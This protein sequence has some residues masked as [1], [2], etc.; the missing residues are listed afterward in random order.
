MTLPVLK[1]DIERYE[2]TCCQL[3]MLIPSSNF[4]EPSLT[5]VT[6]TKGKVKEDCVRKYNL[7]CLINKIDAKKQE[8]SILQSEK[9]ECLVKLRLKYKNE[10]AI[11]PGYLDTGSVANV[12][13]YS[14]LAETFPGQ[15]FKYEPP[16]F[17]LVSVESSQLNCYGVISLECQ[18]S[19]T[20]MDICVHVIN[21]G[22]VFLLGMDSI[23]SFRLTIA[24]Y[25]SQ[26]FI[27]LAQPEIIKHNYN[28]ISFV[29]PAQVHD[30][31]QGIVQS[32]EFCFNNAI[33]MQKYL[34]ICVY[35]LD[36]WC[37]NET[38]R[39]LCEECITDLQIIH[40]A[41]VLGNTFIAKVKP[42]HSRTLK[43]N[44]KFQ[45]F[46]RGQLSQ[47][48]ESKLNLCTSIIPN[49]QYLLEFEKENEEIWASPA[50]YTMTGT[51]FHVENHKF[52]YNPLLEKT[53]I[54]EVPWEVLEQ[55]P[56]CINCE[57]KGR[58][59]CDVDDLECLTSAEFRRILKGPDSVCCELITTAQDQIQSS[60]FLVLKSE[61][62]LDY[63]KKWDFLR[64]IAPKVRSCYSGF[65]R[66][67][68]EELSLKSFNL[69]S[70]QVLFVLMIRQDIY[71]KKLELLRQCSQ[72][73]GH[74]KLPSLWFLNFYD[75]L[76]G[77]K[78][79]T[80][81]FAFIYLKIFIKQ[82]IVNA[83]PA[84]LKVHSDF[85]EITDM[86][87]MNIYIKD[88]EN[89]E[90]LR[91]I[92]QK[93]S[94]EENHL[95]SV[96]ANS[97]LDIG[98]FHS[99]EYPYSAFVF[100]LPFKEGGVR[101]PDTPE[102]TRF[103]SPAIEKPAKEMIL[104][105][106]KA[107]IIKPYFSPLNHQVVWVKKPKELSKE[108]YV[109]QGNN[110]DTYIPGTFDKNNISLR[111]CVDYFF[112][113][114]FLTHTSLI[115]PSP[116]AQI[117]ALYG[118]KYISIFDTSSAFFSMN[119]SSES[120]K[121]TGFDTG[122]R[123]FSRSIHVKCP[124]GLLSSSAMLNN[125]LTYTFRGIENV[126]LYSDNILL[127]SKTENEMISLID[128]V[129]NRLRNHGWR[130][131]PSKMYIGIQKKVNIY[132][133]QLDL[134]NQ[135]LSPKN[136]HIQALRQTKLPETKTALR[137]FL[138][139]IQFI[140][141][142]LCLASDDLANLYS[143]TKSTSFRWN[144]ETLTSFNNILK[145]LQHENLIYVCLP[146][147]TRMLFAGC[148][149]S[150]QRCSWVVWQLCDSN[151][152]R[153][154]SYNAK[155]FVEKSKN[156]TIALLELMG[157]FYCLKNIYEEFGE[158]QPRLQI[159]TDSLPIL[160]CIFGS[161]HNTKLARIRCFL[162]SLSWVDVDF[163]KS[164]SA[165]LKFPDYFTRNTAGSEISYKQKL[166][167]EADIKI[168]KIYNSKIDK[169][170]K[171]SMTSCLLML[172]GLLNLKESQL[173]HIKTESYALDMNNK[174]IYESINFDITTGCPETPNAANFCSCLQV[175]TRSKAR[176]KCQNENSGKELMNFDT[177]LES[178]LLPVQESTKLR[179]H[180]EELS[181]EDKPKIQLFYES[182]KTNSPY[183]DKFKFISQQKKDPIYKSI[184]QE[185]L[186]RDSF[187]E[188]G[189]K[190]FLYEEL[191]MCQE[192]P[193]P[194]LRF[195]KVCIPYLAAHHLI[196]TSHRYLGHIKQAKLKNILSSKFKIA[197]FDE[198][199]RDV[200]LQ[201]HECEFISKKSAATTRRNFNKD[202][203]LL[204]QAGQ[205]WFIDE[206]SVTN[207]SIK[208]KPFKMLVA[209]DAFSQY[210]VAKT[211]TQ[212]LTSEGF[213]SFIQEHL[214]QKFHS[215]RYIVTDNDMKL[216]SNLVNEVCLKLS[217]IKLQS[218]AYSPKSNLAELAAR[219]I[220][221]L[222]RAS[223]PNF[224]I[225]FQEAELVLTHVLLV[226]N[227][228]NFQNS[229][230]LSPYSLMFG[231]QSIFILPDLV[232]SDTSRMTS[233]MEYFEYCKRLS[234]IYNELRYS[235]LHYNEI[236]NSQS[237]TAG[238][239][240]HDSQYKLG[241]II[242]LDN[243]TQLKGGRFKLEPKFRGLFI[244]VGISQ[245]TLYFRPIEE[246][247]I[248]NA[249]NHLNEYQK[250]FEQGQTLPVY[251]ADKSRAKLFRPLLL[252]PF[253]YLSYSK[254]FT[255]PKPLYYRFR[256]NQGF[257]GES[258][259]VFTD[260]SIPSDIEMAD[261]I[262]NVSLSRKLVPR[263]PCI[264]SEREK[265]I[266]ELSQLAKKF[267]NKPHKMKVTFNDNVNT[268]YIQSQSD[269]FYCLPES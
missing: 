151:K 260:E 202:P 113:N 241:D 134:E 161:K 58:F 81:C 67:N 146:D 12:V 35:V 28:E 46:N 163:K 31:E 155:N 139:G 257:I 40:P 156:Y 269:I 212:Q 51:D 255:L 24:P 57:K 15:T 22:N 69:K 83:I 148:D 33:M 249:Q 194:G 14:V 218:Q 138:G 250:C 89:L 191:L 19:D 211:L 127:M 126:S 47:I 36:C 188:G 102:K 262:M 75:L 124:M 158:H 43:T 247:S 193:K 136:D 44:E 87:K 263:K 220:L 18:I 119:L 8:I 99:D 178:F 160:L 65:I 9:G 167:S 91:D 256:E 114:S 52:I 17:N 4:Q 242:T 16:H 2:P 122:I 179:T 141:P 79:L 181:C 80:E 243:R 238:N 232:K 77:Q 248:Q 131:R 153:V 42:R 239:N 84:N 228:T 7:N 264:L 96:F 68:K 244:V 159:F 55:A 258:L 254:A 82:Q 180:R 176:L 97:S 74:R 213:C 105:L 95:K 259:D 177:P 1:I 107:G 106:E 230:Y 21:K 145:L 187:I 195:Y 133:Y 152:P 236:R 121:W 199:C 49:Q 54:K 23:K 101:V 135:S 206:V 251:S 90:R 224:C 117:K 182:F 129:L 266:K 190:Y 171:Y 76:I 246:K 174:P 137:S 130:L 214:I 203:A 61:N 170:K 112:L 5:A 143:L 205:A 128:K 66:E 189:S 85:S 41:F 108:E 123:G 200:L 109:A 32:L 110:P 26:C 100:D 225:S 53:A 10:V 162:T 231:R 25:K 183:L 215:V 245:S 45:I 154:I 48:R 144:D 50:G 217:I 34:Y 223:L 233:K 72:I 185:C 150:T 168:C 172:E 29:N 204:N 222:F 38:S 216:R 226:L 73:C 149:S 120:A 261:K 125:S 62:H 132:G 63:L 140:S 59:F 169:S 71:F 13:S 237:G 267:Y 219:L 92:I 116:L 27:N 184:Y 240:K 221:D 198:I 235:M 142:F 11:L 175:I 147:Y 103:V 173:E 186:V 115:Q 207:V 166:P 201:C 157:I 94:L 30:I 234:K 197:N 252:F 60:S 165:I 227:A 265:K 93:V 86:N 64:L 56:K 20:T 6:Y 3:C 209:I 196:L 39:V 253:E 98:C 111:L 88:Q 37:L 192:E 70:D 208:G 78:V 268:Y 104:T 210:I 118:M 229:K 164:D